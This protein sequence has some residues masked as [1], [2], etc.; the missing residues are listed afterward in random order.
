MLWIEVS[1]VSHQSI[2]SV[3]SQ[4][5]QHN[6]AFLPQGTKPGDGAQAAYRSKLEPSE[7]IISRAGVIPANEHECRF[8]YYCQFVITATF[9]KSASS[10]LRVVQGRGGL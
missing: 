1:P 9:N 5:G 4:F 3:Y 6:V 7:H 8:F 10:L 2:V